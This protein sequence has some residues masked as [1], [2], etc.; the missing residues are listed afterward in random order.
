[1]PRHIISDNVPE[2]GRL[3]KSG[4]S[5]SGNGV[6]GPSI[7]ASSAIVRASRRTGPLHSSRPLTSCGDLLPTTENGNKSFKGV[8]RGMWLLDQRPPLLS[9]YGGPEL[10]W[11]A[12][13]SKLHNLDPMPLRDSLPEIENAGPRSSRRGNHIRRCHSVMMVAR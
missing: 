11:A 3:G 13:W 2:R 8:P 5:V 7:Q 10:L 4:N 9:P 6:G 1:M 12:E